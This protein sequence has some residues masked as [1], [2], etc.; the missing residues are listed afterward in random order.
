VPIFSNTAA[1]WGSATFEYMQDGILFV[2]VVIGIYTIA[3][4]I[5]NRLVGPVIVGVTPRMLALFTMFQCALFAVWLCMF[6]WV[7]LWDKRTHYALQHGWTQTYVKT[8]GVFALTIGATGLF[9]FLRR[10]SIEAL[11]TIKQ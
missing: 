8:A 11:R 1:W 10:L 7:V 6:K 9:L 2:A 3:W 4:R 5:A